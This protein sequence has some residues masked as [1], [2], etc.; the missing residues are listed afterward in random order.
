MINYI[1]LLSVHKGDIKIYDGN[2][3]YKSN[4]I[5]A[6]CEYEDKL[7]LVMKRL[8]NDGAKCVGLIYDINNG[9]TIAVNLF[10]KNNLFA[11]Y[12]PKI[13]IICL[14][15]YVYIVIKYDE[16]YNLIE[17][18]C[19]Y[20]D[21]FSFPVNEPN[22]V[23]TSNFKDVNLSLGKVN[24]NI[25]TFNN[26]IYGYKGKLFVTEDEI[27][28]IK[29]YEKIDKKIDSKKII[30]SKNKFGID[31]RDC[32]NMEKSTKIYF[33]KCIS[34]DIIYYKNDTMIVKFESENQIGL[35]KLTI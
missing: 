4:E 9:E 12:N 17:E 24:D 19:T 11:V 25:I 16:Y 14:D 35:Y 30:L 26:K 33:S 5:G 22:N 31:I 23:K 10:D 27:C 2:K 15:G 21:I 28:N 20:F 7:I 3:E 6:I 18:F 1:K 8:Y 34:E 13:Q 32:D 29:K